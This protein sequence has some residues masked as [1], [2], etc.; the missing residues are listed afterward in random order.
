MLK[1]KAVFVFRI[2]ELFLE[3]QS[4]L[5]LGILI[6]GHGSLPKEVVDNFNNTGTSHIIAV[7]GY[8]ITIIIGSLTILAYLFGRR[9]SFWLSVL[10]IISFV[11]ITGASAS[12]V[13]AGIMGFLFALSGYIGRQYSVGSSIFFAGFIMLVINPKILFWDA[14]FQLSFAAS[15]GIIYFFPLFELLTKNW[16]KLFGIKTIILGTLSAVIATL[17]LILLNFGL[18]SLT[19]PIV[20]VLVLPLIPATM[21]FGFFSVLPIVGPG[22]AMIDN[23]LLI[24]I[25]K[26][27]EFFAH[28][29][30]GVMSQKISIFI[31][32][33]II[34]GI[35]GLYF[36]LKYILKRIQSKPVKE[37]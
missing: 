15:L 26:V 8:N 7:S 17:P 16:P 4:S 19:A 22:L 34:G 5:V 6:G 28:I 32:W 30:H 10:T 21:F 9:W 35:F 31:F 37:I 36:G 12:V 14:G 24:Y 2:S 3:P 33:L 29:P 27:T 18:L 13:R 23:W 1:I 11:I 25:L 20:N